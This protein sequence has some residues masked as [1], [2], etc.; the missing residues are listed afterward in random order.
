MNQ[1]LMKTALAV[2]KFLLAVPCIAFLVWAERQGTLPW[3]T[4]RMGWPSV[5]VD[6]NLDLQVAVNATLLALL[7]AWVLICIR[8]QLTFLAFLAG[9]AIS[10]I[11]IFSLWQPTGVILWSWINDQ[12]IAQI[13][14]FLAFWGFG[15][16]G[17]TIS[18]VPESIAFKRNRDLVLYALALAVTPWLSLDRLLVISAFVTVAAFEIQ[19]RKKS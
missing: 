14:S 4:N 2:L 19:R 16:A 10:S 15:Y 9:A 6:A 7:T 13:T 5:Y 1:R 11:L 12:M 18:R 8:R 17:F 3:L